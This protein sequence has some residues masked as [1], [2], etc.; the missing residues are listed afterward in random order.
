MATF[1]LRKHSPMYKSAEDQIVIMAEGSS[2]QCVEAL[3]A[4][5]LRANQS[6]VNLAQTQTVPECIL[7]SAKKSMLRNADLD[8]H[9]D[10]EGVVYIDGVGPEMDY[11]TITE[12]KYVM[13]Q[14]HLED[15]G[16][17]MNIA[18]TFNQLEAECRRVGVVGLADGQ[19][20]DLREFLEGNCIQ[21]TRVIEPEVLTVEE[22]VAR[23]V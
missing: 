16:E 14:L 23:W 20:D 3:R 6:L 4:H 10:L 15:P 21:L 12:D 2:E 18:G 19:Y 8:I 11:Y 22:L 17:V 1:H 5:L 7:Q 9:V 13:L